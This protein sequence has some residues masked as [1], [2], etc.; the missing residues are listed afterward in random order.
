MKFVT[1]T[2]PLLLVC[3][4]AGGCSI[5][6]AVGSKFTGAQKVA[7]QYR[8]PQEP[9]LVLVENYHNPA[10]TRLDAQRLG[11][12]LAE[13]LNDRGVAPVVDPGR[14]ESLQG[15]DDYGTMPIEKVGQAVG[16][17]Q[18]LY[19]NLREF[20]SSGTVGD[21]AV[22]GR[23]DMH[24]RVVDAATGR[25]RWPT[26]ASRGYRVTVETP[27]SGQR[28]AG[29]VAVREQLARRAAHEIGKLFRTWSPEDETVDGAGY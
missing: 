29:E 26:D 3:L 21:D 6:G 7:P 19:V 23:A 24:V 27:W 15:R 18:V 17:R 9:M 8:P 28:R 5:V 14:V 25:T 2:C 11:L 20:G 12:R 10:A 16:A 13:E 4:L 22:K 1:R